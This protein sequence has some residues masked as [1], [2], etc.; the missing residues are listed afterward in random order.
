MNHLELQALRQL[1]FM[2]IAEAAT[3]ISGDSNVTTWQRWEKGEFAIPPVVSEKLQE[4]NNKRRERLN[5][6]IEKINNRIGNN[7]MRFFTD[8]DA[9][10]EV[11]PD[12]DYLEWKIYQ[13][14]ASELYSD[15]LEH[16]C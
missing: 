16:L 4:M 3:Y 12:G 11:Y 15:H 5:A 7:T 8:Y 1:F 10:R 2:S 13:S 6:I 14:V 9:F